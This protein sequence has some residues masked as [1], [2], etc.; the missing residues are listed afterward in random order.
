[1]VYDPELRD[2][3]Q[4]DLPSSEWEEIR[5]HLS[6]LFRSAQSGKGQERSLLLVGSTASSECQDLRTSYH[7]F[8]SSAGATMVEVNCAYNLLTSYWPL[9]S[10]LSAVVPRVAAEAPDVVRRYAAELSAIYPEL[11]REL[12]LQ[13]VK[14]IEQITLTPSERRLHRESERAYRIITGI[15]QFLLLAQSSVP[16]LSHG[17]LVL[18]WDHLQMADRPTLL[19]FRRLNR[20]INQASAPIILVATLDPTSGPSLE[21]DDLTVAPELERYLDWAQEHRDLVAT[22]RSQLLGIEMPLPSSY[23]EAQLEPLPVNP[24][25]DAPMNE[26]T[27]M[28]LA[29]RAFAQGHIEQ[30]CAYA[31]QAIRLAFFTLNMEGAIFLGRQIIARL[32]EA[33]FDADQFA[34]TWQYLLEAHPYVAMEFSLVGIRERHDVLIAAWK[35]V[36]LAQTFL[37][38]HEVAITCYQR[39]LDLAITSSM[40]A[41]LDMYLGLLIGKRLRTL[42][43]AQ[44]YLNQGLAEIEG[45]EDDD[46]RLERGW[47]TNALALMVYQQ[48]HFNE[49]LGLVKRTIQIMAPV[50]SSEATYLKINLISNISYVLEDMKRLNESLTMW[51]VFHRYMGVASDLFAKHFYFRKAGLQIKAGD[52]A[53]AFTSYQESYVQARQTDDT[54]HMDVIARG[55]GRAAYLTE[56]FDEAATW[57]GKSAAH[58]EEI[59]DYENLPESLLAQALCS[60]R[61]GKHTSAQELVNR[62]AD[63]CRTLSLDWSKAATAAQEALADE[64]KLPA[65]EQA[66]LGAVGTRLNRPFSPMNLYQGGVWS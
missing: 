31:I 17:P 25:Q 49:A 41:S 62:S 50:H 28:A 11:L 3:V 4:V 29:M 54:F 58:R 24:H 6:A 61:A 55:C 52:L 36:A 33:P 43:E 5:T 44:A 7:T 14:S 65:W 37:E 57:Y 30:G 59:G 19:A 16:S 13:P 42:T 64:S 10:L 56:Q 20:W 22:V 1:M 18:W 2:G 26:S 27:E 35:A 53:G 15:C 38:H 40:R 8:V 60:F 9:R 66:A 47:I 34:E 12:G 48:K 21:L 23:T 46:A 32:H 63:L 51:S 39:A 45:Q